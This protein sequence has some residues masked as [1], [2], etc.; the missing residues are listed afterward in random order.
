MIANQGEEMLAGT[1]LRIP[2]M[3]IFGEARLRQ[4]VHEFVHYQE[5]FD[6]EEAPEEP[7][8]EPEIVDMPKIYRPAPRPGKAQHAE[9]RS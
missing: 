5:F 3:L 7:E 2:E 8:L 4:F 9:I 6:R 1:M